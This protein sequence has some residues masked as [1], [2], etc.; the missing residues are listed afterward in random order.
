MDL[1]VMGAGV[2]GLA[3]AMA[4]GAP[5]FEQADAPGGLC[6]S[7]YLPA[8]GA[9]LAAAAEPAAM[10][11]FEVGGGHW[12][13]GGDPEVMALLADLVPMRA[14]ERRAA[15]RLG[16][17]IVPY[18]LQQHT[19]HLGPEVA[20]RAVAEMS[21]GE[22]AAG[23]TTMREWLRRSF[24]ETLCDLFFFP[25]NDRYTAGLAGTVAPQDDFKSPT[26]GT[27]LPGYNSRFRYP[28]GGLDRL[29][30]AMA[31]RCDLRYRKRV[32]RIDTGARV[33]HFAD[34]SEQPYGRVISTLP[35]H[36]AVSM[37]GLQLPGIPDPYTSVLVLN[38]AAERGER[39]PDVHWLYE[40]DSASGFHRIGFYSNVE[41]DFLPR[42][43]RQSGRDVSMYLEWAFRGGR[44]PTPD[45]VARLTREAVAELRE[46]G[47]IGRA[48][49]TDPSW[50]E[51]AYTWSLPGSTWREEAIEALEAEGVHQTGRYA[52]WRFQGIA[53]SIGEGLAAARS[54]VPE[55]AVVA[56]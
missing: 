28:V 44:R 43:R 6:R 56:G 19:D 3:A 34:G 25:F 18:P 8:A 11:R 48:H 7:Y 20:R 36:T 13:F 12:I 16:G 9:P 35:L 27:P 30:A 23:A 14:Y 17:R 52:R 4:T 29:V 40:P 41:P 15:L 21:S 45:E 32:V 46:R 38:V 50:V 53:A 47:Y 1:C 51:V 39:C 31:E 54:L 5:V 49:V 55:A 33:L 26:A 42:G 37:A 24:G 2:T 10:F 22:P